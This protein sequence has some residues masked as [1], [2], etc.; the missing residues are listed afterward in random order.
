MR[1]LPS[2]CTSVKFDG[3]AVAAAYVELVVLSD[4]SSAVA[5]ASAG[6]DAH[7][8]DDELLAA[9]RGVR[10]GPGLEAAPAVVDL[11]RGA[12]EVD[13]AI[14][15]GEDGGERRRRSGLAAAA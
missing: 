7:A 13:G 8:V 3:D 4:A 10:A 1:R 11:L 9:E 6:L 5:M 12:G 14:F 15:A 2:I